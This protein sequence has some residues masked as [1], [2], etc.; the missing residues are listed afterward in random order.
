MSLTDQEFRVRK[1]RTCFASV[2]VE[3]KGYITTD[4]FKETARR[5]VVYGKLDKKQG[6]AITKAIQDISDNVGIKEGDKMTLEQY[7]A[8]AV[9]LC[10]D[11]LGPDYTRALMR[12]LFDA[13]D[14]NHDG[15]ISSEDF[16]LYFKCMGINEAHAKSSFDGIDA[17][18]DGLITKEEFLAAAI[19]FFYGFDTTSGAT[20]FYGPLVN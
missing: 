11:P 20:Q 10:E 6:K 13:V 16:R 7:L 19:E 18:H 4:D 15:V 9:K 8:G 3:N 5:F 14:A 17:N 12:V 1:L 2:D